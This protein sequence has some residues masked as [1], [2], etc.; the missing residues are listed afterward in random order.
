MPVLHL[1]VGPNGAGKTTFYRHVLQP[2]TRLPFVNADEIARIRWPGK[3]E[4]RGH[5]AALAAEQQRERLMAARKSFVA[6]TVFSHPSKLE[7]IR[8]AKAHG[9]LATLHVILVPEELTV[10]RVGLRV[11][12]GGHSVPENKIR[13]RYRRLW[14]NVRAALKDADDAC[15]YDNSRANKPYREVARYRDGEPE[16][17]PQWPKW[18]PLK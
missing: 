3:E 8:R 15:V 7:L 5:E 4:A 12:Q 14:G 18:S 17:P 13:S 10:V 11:E 2:A 16:Y 9:Y 1:I 6:E